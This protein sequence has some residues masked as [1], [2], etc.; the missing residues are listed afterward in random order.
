MERIKA[1]Y[2]SQRALA[3]VSGVS[4]ATVSRIESG[5]QLPDPSTLRLLAEAL[6]IDNEK[7]LQM[8]GYLE[9]DNQPNQ[10]D[11]SQT[12]IDELLN[13]RAENIELK[14]QVRNLKEVIKNLTKGW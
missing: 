3:N 10:V 5:L 14:S 1:G 2:R 4:S 13:L 12:I 9:K 11:V 6:G 8:A 7:L